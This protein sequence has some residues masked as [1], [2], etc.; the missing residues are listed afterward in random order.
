MPDWPKEADG[1][2]RGASG[3]EGVRP[4]TPGRPS[5]GLVFAG[6]LAAVAGDFFLPAAVLLALELGLGIDALALVAVFAALALFLLDQASVVIGIGPLALPLALVF[7]LRLR[8]YRCGDKADQ[9]GGGEMRLR[10]VMSAPAVMLGA[11][12]EQV[13]DELRV[14]GRFRLWDEQINGRSPEK[15][16]HEGSNR[17][18]YDKREKPTATHDST[19]RT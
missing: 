14:I 11:D 4:S 19:N 6:D 15:H 8:V 10:M 16:K 1:A 5:I 18:R 3:V 13:F 12:R 9:G 7:L 2:R 17:E